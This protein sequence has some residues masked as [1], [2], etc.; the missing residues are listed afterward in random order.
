MTVMELTGG[1]LLPSAF[2][3]SL[4]YAH[5]CQHAENVQDKRIMVCIGSTRLARRLCDLS[6]VGKFGLGSASAKLSHGG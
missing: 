5:N 6:S 1:F 4:T 3:S 2:V